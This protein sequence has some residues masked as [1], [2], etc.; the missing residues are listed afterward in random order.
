MRLSFVL[1]CF[2]LIV[3]PCMVAWGQISGDYKAIAT[4]NWDDIAIWQKYNGSTWEAATVKPDASNNVFIEGTWIVTLQEAEACSN[5][6]LFDG[7]SVPLCGQL[8]LATYPL[9]LSGYI[10][11]YTGA[12]P[13]TDATGSGRKKITISGPGGEIKVVGNTRA[14]TSTGQWGAYST[15]L[16]TT[17]VVFEIAA[18]PGQTITVNT[19]IKAQSWTVTSGIFDAQTFRASPDNGTT[20]DFTIAEG[21][22]F[23]SSYTGGAIIQRQGTTPTG[24][25]TINGTLEVNGAAPS[26]AAISIV[27][28]ANGT[29]KYNGSGAQS[30]LT[31][32][33]TGSADPN[34]YNNLIL[35]NTGVKTLGLNTTVNGTLSLQGTASLSLGSFTL[36]YGGSSTLEYDGSTAQTTSVELPGSGVN[37]L[38]I[39][40]TNGVTLSNATTVSGSCSIATGASIV[41]TAGQ[42]VLGTTTTTQSVGTSASTLGGIG[43]SLNS[44]ADNLGNVSVTRVAGSSGA[45]TVSGKTGIN[46]KWTITSD[47]APAAG[48]DLTLMWDAGDDNGKNPAAAQVW[49]STDAGSTWSAIGIPVDASSSRSVTVNTNSFS[50]WTVSDGSNTLPVQLASFTAIGSHTGAL[51]MWKTATE[52][53]C[54]GFEVERR[55]IS[56]Q[57]SMSSDWKNVGFVCGS[58]SSNLPREYLFNDAT[59]ESGRFAYRIKQMDQDG[60]F[61]YYNAAEVEI[62]CAPKMMTLCDNYPNPFNPTTNI[63][64]SVPEDGHAT[65]TIFNILGQKVATLFDDFA[66]AGF[67]MKVAFHASNLSSGMYLSRLEYNGHTMVKRMIL[68]K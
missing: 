41:E 51:L 60:S 15:A 58:G 61:T 42:Y 20:G 68:S 56:G 5:L 53:N 47:N 38:A 48:R 9:E 27:Y 19:N 30:L 8:A 49:K 16:T 24:T 22:T 63:E 54:Y 31:A 25:V 21:A 64:F 55:A 1:R 39:K 35:S 36:T 46:R 40:N 34:T 2:L 29:V 6:N 62:G 52:T 26:I 44:G 4:G 10:R 18:N 11:C 50:Q 45:V 37:N 13:G 28:G 32:V 43:V 66:Q 65:L 57:S 7:A 12:V 14:L 33:Y 67:Y 59:T 3:I 23:R 17:D